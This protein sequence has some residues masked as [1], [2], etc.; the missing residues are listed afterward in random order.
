MS[1]VENRFS[2]PNGEATAYRLICVHL[3]DKLDSNEQMDVANDLCA[4]PGSLPEFAKEKGWDVLGTPE[5]RQ[6]LL[7]GFNKV[8][9]EFQGIIAS[10]EAD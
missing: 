6:S 10:F 7:N 1:D 3:F 4:D 5:F 9:V 8:G 2:T